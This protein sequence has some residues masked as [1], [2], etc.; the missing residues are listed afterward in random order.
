[1]TKART[2]KQKVDTSDEEEAASN[3]EDEDSD[4][5]D[6]YDD[7]DSEDDI[8]TEDLEDK[9]SGNKR[10]HEDGEDEDSPSR[11]RTNRKKRVKPPTSEE[12]VRL[13]ETE[14]LF[15]SNL[16]R[17]QIDEMLTELKPKKSVKRYIGPWIE[18][19]KNALMKLDESETSDLSHKDWLET[20]QIKLPLKHKKP[21]KGKGS[22]TFKPPVDLFPIG[23]HA[24]GCPLGPL[25]SVDVAIVIPKS[26]TLHDDNLNERYYLKRA[27]YLCYIAGQLQGSEL[28][29]PDHKSEFTFL[30]DDP[31]KPLLVLH[32]SGKLARFINVRLVPVLEENSFKFKRLLPSK[33]NVRPD[34]WGIK[35]DILPPT[36]IYNA[37]ILEDLVLKDNHLLK[38]ESFEQNQSLKDAFVL[39]RVWLKQREFSQ[40]FGAFNSHILSMLLVYLLKIQK[41]NKHMSS[42][43]IIRH[44]WLY[45]GESDWTENGPSLCDIEQAGELSKEDFHVYY[46]VVFI[47]VTGLFN[48]AARLNKFVYLQVKEESKVAVQHLDNHEING[49]RVLFMEKMPFIRQFDVIL[50]FNDINA[51]RKAVESKGDLVNLMDYNNKV[52]PEF[53]RVVTELLGKGLGER[54]SG[55]A[56]QTPSNG[57]W[58]VDVY[59]PPSGLVKIGL[60]LNPTM[61]LSLVDK[62]PQADDSEAEEFREFWG[63]KCELRRFK[64]GTVCESVVWGD[65]ETTIEQRRSISNDIIL[66]LLKNKLGLESFHSVTQ[67]FQLAVEAERTKLKGFSREETCRQVHLA[68]EHLSRQLMDLPDLPLSIVSVHCISPVYRFTDPFPPI[69]PFYHKTIS[70]LVD[71]P[72]RGRLFSE[73]GKVGKYPPEYIPSVD[74]VV[75]M[76]LTQKWPNDIKAGRRLIAAFNI[77]ITAALKK[78]CNLN[79]QITTDY[80]VVN[81]D[82]YL[83]RLFLGYSKEIGLLKLK[84]S[85]EGVRQYRDTPESLELEKKF[86]GLP[87]ITGAIYRL[88][89]EYPG[90]SAATCLAQRWF[91]AQLLDETHFPRE[92]IDLLM[93]HIFLIPQPFKPCLTVL[94]AFLRFLAFISSTDW[95]TVPV[96]VNFNSLLTSDDLKEMED[97]FRED[98]SAFPPL[99]L[100][101]PYDRSGSLWSKTVPTLATL[102][103]VA[104]LASASLQIIEKNIME[105]SKFDNMLKVFEAPLSVY[106]AVIKLVKPFQLRESERFFHSDI[107]KFQYHIPDKKPVLPILHFNPVDL[108]LAELRAQ[109]SNFALFFHDPHGGLDIGV[110]FK[111][112]YLEKV[113]FQSSLI[114][115]RK[116]VEINGS[117]RLEA[118]V[119]SI[120]EGFKILGNG[121]VESIELKKL[122]I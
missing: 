106:D 4:Q 86:I 94:P 41:I 121:I 85:E 15:Q 2:V 122:K 83:F 3:F 58:A 67:A 66:Y 84:I 72:V 69:K 39:L 7:N 118:N 26:F 10:K 51:M 49:F 44:V 61:A 97:A 76:A 12:M 32:P 63:E 55:I 109:Y 56:V 34:W 111:P 70:P 59:S 99:F 24:L 22:F 93:A 16:F 73:E 21:E 23:S 71:D 107:S 78:H 47:D 6:G 119:D 43:Q 19:L 30:S 101:T 5:E 90:F 91:A 98:R 74:C 45:L 25:Y 113:K 116:P 89:E 110:L 33:N 28:L 103:R 40:G 81:K 88:S 102:V 54:M 17:L 95:A 35:K 38:K 11:K 9:K 37:G 20:F 120:F 92:L 29:S 114:A 80:F 64:D 46:D 57:T 96:I 60:N 77:A 1:M 27:M 75:Q 52:V 117:I 42:Y 18:N 100:A 36:P 68:Y 82:G 48:M 65:S 105:L 53:L 62:G 115:G 87:K 8:V 13:R 79:S 112:S 104:K 108:Y 31:S 50:S 14:N